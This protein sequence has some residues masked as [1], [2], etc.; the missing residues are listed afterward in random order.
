MPL[1]R[2]LGAL[3]R[4]PSTV[5]SP[6][7]SSLLE[8]WTKV[9]AASPLPPGHSR[10]WLDGRPWQV[11]PALPG[12]VPSRVRVSGFVYHFE[13][14][15]LLSPGPRQILGFLGSNFPMLAGALGT[16]AGPRSPP[17]PTSPSSASGEIGA[18]RRLAGSVWNR[19]QVGGNDGGDTCDEVDPGP[20]DAYPPLHTPE[21]PYFMCTHVYVTHV[22]TP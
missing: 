20:G 1:G 17:S 22:C 21:Q 11:S 7:P 15:C 3:H 4:C 16:Y 12:C 13:A 10:G 6:L 2:L 9:T 14:S 5:A 8:P 18:Q 19:R